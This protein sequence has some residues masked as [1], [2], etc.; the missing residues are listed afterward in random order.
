M[1]Q[2]M[3][4]GTTISLWSPI[5]SQPTELYT[6]NLVQSG[7][8]RNS[9]LEKLWR[10]LYSGKHMNSFHILSWERRNWCKIIE[11]RNWCKAAS[12]DAP[13]HKDGKIA[14]IGLQ[15]TCASTVFSRSTPQRL[16][17]ILRPQEDVH[18]KEIQHRR[19]KKVNAETETHFE[20]NNKSGMEKLE[21][22]CI[23]LNGNYVE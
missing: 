1:W 6:I 23:A 7:K 17:S 9:Q 3:K 13:Y 22:R 20:A 2:W 10:I 16:F 15:I 21:N 11:R 4:Y 18:R 12:V 19:S 14:W 8:K 5:N